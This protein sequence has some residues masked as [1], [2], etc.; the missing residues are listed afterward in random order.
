MIPKYDVL[1]DGWDDCWD[2]CY[3]YGVTPVCSIVISGNLGPR[4]GEIHY[5]NGGLI[6]IASDCPANHLRDTVLHEVA[7]WIVY[8]LWGW[9]GHGELWRQVAEDLGCWDMNCPRHAKGEPGREGGNL[10]LCKSALLKS[11]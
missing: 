8:K 7:H 3:E 2:A 11:Y 1:D 10:V 9:Y 6:K 5:G 4:M